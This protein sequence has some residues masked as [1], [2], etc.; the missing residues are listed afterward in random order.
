MVTLPIFPLNIVVFPAESM[1]LHIFE[2]RYRQLIHECDE[3]EI[4]FGMVAHFESK[5]AIYGTEVK[6]EKILK[7]HQDGRMDVKI[8]GKCAFKLHKFYPHCSNRLYPA[9]EVSHLD[10][11]KTTEE[12]LFTKLEF[13]YNKIVDLLAIDYKTPNFKDE[14]LSFQL[15]HQIGLNMKQKIKLLSLEK[16]SERQDLLLDYFN[17]LVPI[18]ESVVEGHH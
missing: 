15:A 11:D 10:N 8:S 14:N 4:D 6:L 2:S 12:S 18:L 17:E 3:N 7:Y 5:M 9:A 1:D 13:F 16:E